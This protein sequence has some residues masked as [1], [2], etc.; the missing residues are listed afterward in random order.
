MARTGARVR[1]PWTPPHRRAALYPSDRRRDMIIAVL[2]PLPGF[3]MIDLGVDLFLVAMVV[4]DL[5]SRRRLH[6]VTLWG[7]AVLV[8]P[9]SGM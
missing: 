3:S 6:P 8:A 4:W 1:L 9:G 5:A 7:G 2:A